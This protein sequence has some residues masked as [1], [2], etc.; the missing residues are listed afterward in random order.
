MNLADINIDGLLI[1][2]ATF[3]IIGLFHPLVIKGEYY[4]G[5]PLCRR[6]FLV[7]AIAATVGSLLVSD[8]T[9]STLLGIIAFSSLWSIKEVTEQVERVRKGWFPSNPRRKK[10][11]DNS[12]V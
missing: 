3:I 7:A 8:I 6:L 12:K 5:A 11:S 4:L 2:A 9:G 1:G 10:Q